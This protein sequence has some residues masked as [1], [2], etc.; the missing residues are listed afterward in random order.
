M[1]ASLN[2]PHRIRPCSTGHGLAGR[3]RGWRACWVAKVTPRIC[4]ALLLTL[5]ACGGSAETEREPDITVTAERVGKWEMSFEDMEF[6]ARAI[7]CGKRLYS[8][9]QKRTAW[10]YLKMGAR[11]GD[12]DSQYM[13]AIMLGVGEDV[14]KDWK[15]A[16][17]WLGVAAEGNIKPMAQKRLRETKEALCAGRTDCEQGFDNIVTEYRHRYGRRATGMACRHI[18]RQRG[19]SLR[20]SR[21]ARTVECKFARLLV[22]RVVL[23]DAELEAVMGGAVSE[24]EPDR[25][26]TVRPDLVTA[27]PGRL[28]F[29]VRKPRSPGMRRIRCPDI[30]DAD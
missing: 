30:G 23:A 20:L 3:T 15:A 28:E 14:P 1:K 21:G 7:K 11:F 9:G 24:P 25:I 27:Y 10:P 19:V 26:G 18:R 8:D 4:A 12:I 2:S 29:A 13:A 22:D 16:A 5:H 6:V 17:G